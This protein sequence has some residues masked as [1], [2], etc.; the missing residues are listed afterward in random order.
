MIKEQLFSKNE[1]IRKLIIERLSK[2]IN[3]FFLMFVY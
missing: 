2:L 3:N 1:E